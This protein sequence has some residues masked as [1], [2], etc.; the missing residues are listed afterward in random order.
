VDTALETQLKQVFDAVLFHSADEYA[1]A[2]QRYPVSGLAGQLYTVCY[3]REF[4]VPL[5]LSFGQAD[6]LDTLM[7]ELNSANATRERWDYGWKVTQTLQDGSLYATKEAQSRM[8]RPVEFML[9]DLAASVAPGA[10]IRAFLSKEDVLSQLG[11]Y[12]AQP[13]IAPSVEDFQTLVRLYWNL[14]P[15]GAPKLLGR[16]TDSFNALR[17]PFQFKTLRYRSQYTR[18]DSAVLFVGWR[19]AGIALRL[20]FDIYPEVK[21]YLKPYT[22]LFAK[23]L[24]PGLGL[25]EDPA[26]GQSFGMSR[27]NL[28]A[29]AMVNAYNKQQQSQEAR[30]S[31]LRALFKLAGLSLDKPYLSLSSVDHYDRQ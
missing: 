28:L 8:L 10:W 27:C 12:I 1:I 4:R 26:N 23:K 9:Q 25:A 22:P 20:A 29:Q 2:D 7:A 16:I 24:A 17:V 31:E 15:E 5:D 19:Y 6:P 14:E 3:S 13:E 11:F 30:I 18:A 21:P